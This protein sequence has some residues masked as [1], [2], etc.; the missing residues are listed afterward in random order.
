M[1]HSRRGRRGPREVDGAPVERR[2]GAWGALLLPLLIAGWILSASAVSVSVSE[3]HLHGEPGERT[4]ATFLLWND[5]AESVA[6]LISL[7]D[8]DVDAGSVTQIRPPATLDRSCAGWLVA[9]PMRSLLHPESEMEVRLDLSV[10]EAARGTYWAGLLVRVLPADP[11]GEGEGIRL[12]RQFL[13]RTFLTAGAG[14]SAGRVRDVRPRG[15]N[16]LGVAVTFENTGNVHLRNVSGLI[17]VEDAAGDAIV[18]IAIPPFD[19]LPGSTVLRIAQGQWPLPGAGAYLIRAV[20]D[21]GDDRL[22]AGQIVLRVPALELRTVGDAASLPA[23]LDGDGLYEDIDGDGLLDARD[24]T[25]LRT[26]LEAAAIQRNARAFDFD[27]DGEV[28]ASDVLRL[29]ELVWRRPR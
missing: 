18:E 11:A 13:I 15:M 29:E 1:R 10:P 24:A 3:F 8:W 5:D 2:R 26:F 19:A 25:R 17:V 20:I 14:T 4:A 27:N 22:V 7:V 16:P 6:V 23:D 9:T 21:Y 12:V 28:T